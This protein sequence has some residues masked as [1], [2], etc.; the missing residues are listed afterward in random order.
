MVEGMRDSLVPLN[1]GRYLRVS[2]SLFLEPYEGRTRLKVEKSVY[3]YQLDEEG[4]QW[5]VRYDYLRTP[6]DPHPGMHVQIRGRLHEAE[7]LPS[8][9]T[10]ERVHFPTGRVSIEAVIRMLVEQFRV[11]PNEEPRI[12]RPVLAESERAFQQIAHRDISGPAA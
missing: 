3:Q 10:L 8:D 9:A 7:V 6:S 5:V 12:W 11:P 4:D 1:D 2:V